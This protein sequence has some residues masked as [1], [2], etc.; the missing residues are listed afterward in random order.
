[1]PKKP[2][3]TNEPATDISYTN[4]RDSK[5][6]IMR[7]ARDDCEA[8]WE[9]FEPYADAH[10]LTQIRSNFDE[11]YWEMYLTAYL[12]QEGYEVVCHKTGPDAGITVNGHRVWF[13]A[14]S[15]SRGTGADQ[16]PDVKATTVD[17][18]VV[19]QEVPNDKIILRYLNSIS[20]KYTKQFAAWT[21]NKIVNPN[22]SL[23]IAINPKRLRHE[24]ID[25]D[26]PRILQAAFAVGSPYVVLDEVT[27]KPVASG[28]QF[29]DTIKKASGSSVPT[30]VF[31]QQEYTGLSALLCSRVDAVNQPAQIGGDFQLVPNPLATAP[32]PYGFRLK[33]T[34]FRIDAIEGGYQAFPETN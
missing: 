7:A 30:G 22:D 3:F 11:R 34:Y 12:L 10:F 6:P 18:D 19:M 8:L 26:P 14:T 27:A 15:P 23:I 17:Q 28:Y 9:T 32:L 16:V 1:M 21:E 20:E 33:G 13:E 25:A 24:I 4:I 29:R 5:D 2:L 31:T